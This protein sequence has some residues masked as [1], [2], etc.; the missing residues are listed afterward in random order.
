MK[1]SL[2]VINCW[3]S[4][5]ENK[6]NLNGHSFL[7]PFLLAWIIY[8]ILGVRS[9]LY[10]SLDWYYILYAIKNGL[11]LMIITSIKIMTWFCLT[12]HISFRYR[13]WS[14]SMEFPLHSFSGFHFQNIQI[15]EN[16]YLTN[17]NSPDFDFSFLPRTSF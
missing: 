11:L 4:S 1:C 2:S 3:S 9:L 14:H 5:F 7:V 13:W 17:S 15:H 16:D 6:F 12:L 8:N 10:I